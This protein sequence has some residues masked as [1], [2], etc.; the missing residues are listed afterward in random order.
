MKLVTIGDTTWLQLAPRWSQ[1]NPRLGKQA[2][3]S[4]M[5]C[6]DEVRR[7]GD[8]VLE[9]GVVYA[10]VAVEIGLFDYLEGSFSGHRRSY[11]RGR[12]VPSQ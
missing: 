4:D 5:E 2:L 8:D 1:I 10:V 6:S 7:S 12:D 3:Y 9:F 11:W